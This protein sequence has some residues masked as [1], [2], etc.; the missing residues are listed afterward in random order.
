MK[1]TES[2][3]TS[4]L[5]CRADGSGLVVPERWV[6]QVVEL[7]VSPLPLSEPWVRGAAV[8]QGRLVVVVGIGGEGAPREARRSVKA[9]LLALPELAAAVAVEVESVGK[10]LAVERTA[11]PNGGH[12][13]LGAGVTADG[14]DLSWLEVERVRGA[15][16]GL[17]IERT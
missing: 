17:E 1:S 5:E 15:I 3:D 6:D 4:G 14:R 8:H 7:E 2:V 9:V 11:A 10:L 13:W 16:A 12:A